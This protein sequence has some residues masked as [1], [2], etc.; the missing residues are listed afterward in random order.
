VSVVY[1]NSV[2][3]SKLHTIRMKALLSFVC[4]VIVTQCMDTV[5][6]IQQVNVNA[7]QFLLQLLIKRFDEV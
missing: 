4:D 2:R 1:M 5:H 7:I 3:F 6:V